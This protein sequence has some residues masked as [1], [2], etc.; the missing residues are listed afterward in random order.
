MKTDNKPFSV[1]LNL[2]E[3]TLFYFA[4]L[5]ENNDAG[6]V[7]SLCHHDDDQSQANGPGL[8]Y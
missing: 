7:C 1:S 3:K 5:S 6:S 4:S 2:F 8:Y